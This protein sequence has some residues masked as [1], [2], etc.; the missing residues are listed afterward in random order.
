M[1]LELDKSQATR[2]ECD[3]SPRMAQAVTLPVTLAGSDTGVC[4]YVAASPYLPF[5]T[6]VLEEVVA[7]LQLQEND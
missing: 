5:N 6:R 3:I 7:L 2:V 4:V 1:T